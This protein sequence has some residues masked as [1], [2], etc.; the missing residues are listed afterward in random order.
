MQAGCRLNRR[1]GGWRCPLDQ[2]K[3]TC[4]IILSL[5]PPPSP[6]T[7]KILL[8]YR[9]NYSL[10]I[11]LTHHLAV[12]SCLI[13]ILYLLHTEH[14]W[15]SVVSLV[16]KPQQYNCSSNCIVQLPCSSSG[17][18]V[19]VYKVFFLRIFKLDLAAPDLELKISSQLLK[20]LDSGLTEWAELTAMR[21]RICGEISINIYRP[22]WTV[23]KLMFLYSQIY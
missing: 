13:P 21:A 10:T 12:H 1:M 16:V 6:R 4:Q 7:W 17:L 14:V 3:S 22:S 2:V 23:A 15:V 11:L 19:I 9:I 8:L 5:S 20:R 18:T